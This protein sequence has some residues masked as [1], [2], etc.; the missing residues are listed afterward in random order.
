MDRSYSLSHSAAQRTLHRRSDAW[1]YFALRHFAD[2]IWMNPHYETA[3]LAAPVI[4]LFLPNVCAGMAAL[5]LFASFMLVFCSDILAAMLPV[6][7]VTVL[8]SR[9][10]SNYA[11]IVPYWF[12]IAVFAAALIA[13]FVLYRGE[14]RSGEMSKPLILV[15]AATILGGVGRISLTEYLS[16]VSMYY[17]IGLGPFLYLYYTLLLPQLRKKRSYDVLDRFLRT[18]YHV[19]LLAGAVVIWTYCSRFDEFLKLR[20]SL[21][22]DYRNFCATMMLIALPCACMPKTGA[23]KSIAGAAFLY[24]GLLLSG[25]RSGLFFGSLE[26]VLCCLL[27]YFRCETQMRKKLLRIALPLLPVLIALI[28]MAA[29]LLFA[30]R[31]IDGCIISENDSRYIF[32]SQGVTDFLNAPLFGWGLGNMK[33]KGI[34]LGVPGSIV[35]YHNIIAQI[36]GSMGLLGAA[37]FGWL[38]AKRARLLIERRS[39]KMLIACLCIGGMLLIDM[40]N[41]GEIAPFPNAVIMTTLFAILELLPGRYPMLRS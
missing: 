27:A 7:S 33:N 10:Y 18:V 40:T 22:M 8:S 9:I 2:R 3:L 31:L 38:Y 25:S 19:G 34:F 26:L 30:S 36:L 21:Y 1:L 35:W 6:L 20:S 24:A 14:L 41:P 17:V 5:T 39:E 12:V 37:G 4:F 29:K 23:K 16:P 11:A 32:F 13:H 28:Y 15:S